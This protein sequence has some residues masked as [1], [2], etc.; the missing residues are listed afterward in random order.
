MCPFGCEHTE[1]ISHVLNGCTEV[2][3]NFYSQRH[4]CIVKMIVNFLK[5]SRKRYRVVSEKNSETV[6]PLL[7]E[8]IMN[9]NHRKP[10]THV[11]DE[12]AKKCVI[13][14]VTVCSVLYLD[15]AYDTKWKRYEKLVECLGKYYKVDLVVLCFGSLGC[16]LDVWRHEKIFK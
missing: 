9:V 7:R 12:L 15:D 8:E 16:V 11:L 14:E 4:D 3:G 5:E 1:S 13:V 2:F 6:F 10:D